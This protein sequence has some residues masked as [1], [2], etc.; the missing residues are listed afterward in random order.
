MAS[1]VGA[2]DPSVGSALARSTPHFTFLQAMWLL[3][4]SLPGAIPVGH[5]GPPN[6]EPV[7]MRPSASLAFP[8]CDIEEVAEI[9]DGH[10]PYRLTAAFLGLYGAHSPLP[11]YYSEE[12]LFRSEEVADP[13]RD[14]LDIFNHRL[15]SLFYRGLLRY[16][17]HLLYKEEAADEF[18][19]RLFALSG[20]A[21]AEM[22]KMSG[23]KPERLLQFTGQWCQFPR[24][25]ASVIA[26]LSTYLDLPAIHV[27]QCVSRWVYLPLEKQSRLG[28]HA[29]R[30]GVDAT[31]GERVLD[32]TGKFRVSVGPVDYDTY[33]EYLPGSDKMTDLGH[34]AK[35][36]SGGWLAFDVEVIL[37]GEDT[38]RLAVVL[39]SEGRLGLT[40]GLFTQPADDLPVV[41]GGLASSN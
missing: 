38:T 40:A 5:Q 32:R 35:L 25:A 19:W 1:D 17:G 6:R 12:I 2:T 11:S 22:P 18:S 37:R 24:S 14:F 7:R 39:S 26:A 21:A 13:V 41:F 4:R 29:N 28:G 30:L 27:K 34:M 33:L 9:E 23:I 31:V 20:L 15:Y 8:S 16:R 3:H 36:G 10:P